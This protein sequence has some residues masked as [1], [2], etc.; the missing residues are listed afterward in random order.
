MK[1]FKK[2]LITALSA[3]MVASSTAALIASADGEETKS[4][5]LTNQFMIKDEFT[6][7]GW[8]QFYNTNTTPYLE[9]VEEL[10]RTGQ[11]LI[12]LP[13]SISPG[14]S[15]NSVTTNQNYEGFYNDLDELAKEISMYYMYNGS[16]PY[17]FEESYAKIKDLANCVGY[18]LKDEP[19]SA[20]MDSL[21]EYVVQFKQADPSRIPY[22]NLFPNYAGATNLGGTYRL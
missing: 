2:I 7:G 5:P 10:A 1:K 13:H 3:T 18:H 9:Q 16:D 15:G 11:N 20:Q 6:I 12:M 21:A 19:S 8:I 4:E 14:T 22:V 17:N